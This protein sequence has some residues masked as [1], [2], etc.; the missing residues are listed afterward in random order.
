VNE[1]NDVAMRLAKKDSSFL[2]GGAREWARRIREETGKSCSLATVRKTLFWRKTMERTGRGRS[3]GGKPNVV[4]LTSDLEAA[5]G[6][7]DKH[8]ILERLVAEQKS[9]FEPSPLDPDPNERPRR[10]RHHKRL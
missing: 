5:T 7:G 4:G 8:E 9:D 2:A 1:A 10:V 6:E 3:K